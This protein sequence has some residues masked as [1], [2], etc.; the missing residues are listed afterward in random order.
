MNTLAAKLWALQ[1]TEVSGVQQ[2]IQLPFDADAKTEFIQY[3]EQAADAAEQM[4]P[5][6]R[7]LSLKLRPAA[8]RLA[9]VFSVVQQV[10]LG[11]DATGPVDLASTRAGIELA[12]WFLSELERNYL[13]GMCE[14]QTDTLQAHATWIKEKHPAGIDART[15]QQF[16][17]GLGSADKARLTLQQLAEQGYGRFEGARYIPS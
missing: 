9:L 1:G 16:R 4:D 5:D 7:N 12:Q 13:A 3:Y 11:T 10:A 14:H 6:Q 17:R 15:L 8:A 2:S